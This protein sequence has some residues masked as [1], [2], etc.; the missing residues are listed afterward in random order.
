MTF[1]DA[2]EQLENNNKQI[3][4]MKQ[5]YVIYICSPLFVN[6]D[7]FIKNNNGDYSLSAIVNISRKICVL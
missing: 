7:F 5:K 6:K 2:F 3:R 1:R 4:Y